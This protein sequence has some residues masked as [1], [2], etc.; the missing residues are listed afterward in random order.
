M[1]EPAYESPFQ[2]P[3]SIDTLAVLSM[4]STSTILKI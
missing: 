3:L 2:C 1:L 4:K